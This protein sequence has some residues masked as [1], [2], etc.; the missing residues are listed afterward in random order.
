[1]LQRFHYMTKRYSLNP[2]GKELYQYRVVH[3]NIRGAR[4][5]KENLMHHLSENDFPEIVTLNE[6][7]LGSKTRFDLPGYYSASR[8][9][10]SEKG[11][12]HGSMILVRDDIQDVVEIEN[13]RTDFFCRSNWGGNKGEPYQTTPERY[14]LL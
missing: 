8:R 9:E 12:V 3:V 10:V 6:T 2:N 11:G 1:M 4:A 7:K 14:H 13:F 5:N